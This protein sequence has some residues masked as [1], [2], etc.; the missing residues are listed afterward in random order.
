MASNKE[1]EILCFCYEDS[2]YHGSVENET[3]GRREGDEGE[4]IGLQIKMVRKSSQ[5]FLY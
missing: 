2:L 3:K 5:I 4:Y 1:T